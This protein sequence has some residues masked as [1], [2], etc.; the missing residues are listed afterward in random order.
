MTDNKDY[1]NS[2]GKVL[3]DSQ[4]FPWLDQLDDNRRR[5]RKSQEFQ[6]PPGTILAFAGATNPNGWLKADGS[7]VSQQ[8]YPALFQVIG[9]SYGAG[10]QVNTFKLPDLRGRVI[11]GSGK[12]VGLTNRLLGNQFGSEQHALT[13]NEMPAHTHPVNDPGHSHDMGSP[14]RGQVWGVRPDNVHYCYGIDNSGVMNNPPTLKAQTG[15]TV[16]SV[17]GDAPH[18]IVQPSMAFNYI[19]KY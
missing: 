10:D 7:I 19:I 5:H 4:P 13:Q 15:V 6:I 17:G 14:T 12:G 9:D 18:D 2:L 11:V 16:Q 3:S 1:P 8:Q